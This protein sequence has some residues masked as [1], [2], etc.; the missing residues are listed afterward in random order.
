VGGDAAGDHQQA[1]GV[2][3]SGAGHGPAE[4][5]DPASGDADVGL[6][7]VTGR[8]DRAVADNQVKAL[9]S[10]PRILDLTSRRGRSR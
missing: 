4:L 2:D 3:L 6:L 5:G 9:F 7:P 10:Q 8:H 1:A